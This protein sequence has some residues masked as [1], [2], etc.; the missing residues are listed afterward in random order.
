MYCEEETRE[1]EVRAMAGQIYTERRR[2]LLS[3]ARRNAP[4][5]ADA[6]EALHDTFANFLTG[7]DP[8]G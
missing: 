3:I 1:R 7:F 6:E 4:S 5:E 2:Y 8:R